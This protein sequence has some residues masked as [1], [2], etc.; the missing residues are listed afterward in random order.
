MAKRL[1]AGAKLRSARTHI[2]THSHTIYKGAKKPA[3][4]PV[5]PLE[6]KVSLSK[7]TSFETNPIGWNEIEARLCLAQQQLGKLIARPVDR[8]GPRGAIPVRQDPVS[9]ARATRARCT[10]ATAQGRADRPH[11]LVVAADATCVR[12]LG[13]AGRLC[14]TVRAPKATRF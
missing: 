4:A 13:A 12:R 6:T 10:G 14:G 5:R 2:H 3:P 11:H 1:N 8:F 9:L 7:D